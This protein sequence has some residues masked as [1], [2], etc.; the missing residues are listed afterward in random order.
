M[1]N[2]II[3]VNGKQVIGLDRYTKI[4]YRNVQTRINNADK[5]TKGKKKKKKN[6]YNLIDKVD[7]HKI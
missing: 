1:E 7:V 6:I 5:Y 4:K 2:Y 3:Y